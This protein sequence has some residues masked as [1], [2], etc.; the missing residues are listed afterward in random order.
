[1]ILYFYYIVIYIHIAFQTFS[2][3]ETLFEIP[4][5]G[6]RKLHEKWMFTL[7]L[8]TFFIHIYYSNIQQDLV[9]S[10]LPLPCYVIGYRGAV[11]RLS[12]NVA[13]VDSFQRFKLFW[14]H[15]L[16][17]ILMSRNWSDSLWMECLNTRFPLLCPKPII[18]TIYY[19]PIYT[20]FIS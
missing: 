2:Q 4:Q 8:H 18:L 19:I 17:I 1:M 20:Y 11:V 3:C 13:V 12:V 7:N 10:L 6:K 5:N 14:Y 15:A 16:W 9:S